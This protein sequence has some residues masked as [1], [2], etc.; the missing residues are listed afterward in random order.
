MKEKRILFVGTAFPPAKAGSAVVMRELLKRLDKNS[1]KVIAMASDGISEDMDFE[2]RTLRIGSRMGWARRFSLLLRMIN[3]I[4]LY[5]RSRKFAETFSPEVIVAPYPSLDF[6][7]LGGLLARS[8]HIP[9]VPYL[10]D[11]I[12]EASEKGRARKLAYAVQR[13]V[14]KNAARILVMSEGMVDL[15]KRKYGLN[16]VAIP[17]IYDEGDNFVNQ[18][19]DKTERGAFWAGGV[20]GINDKALKRV[21][22]GIVDAGLKFKVTSRESRAHLASL[23]ISGDN[24]EICTLP[25]R[26]EYLSCLQSQ[27]VLILALNRPDES[28]IGSDEL[29]TIFPTKTPEYLASGRPI[30]VH[31][32][33]DYFLA[34]FFKKHK[35]GLVVSDKTKEFLAQSLVSLLLDTE[36]IRDMGRKAKELATMFSSKIVV[37]KF[38]EVITDVAT[39]R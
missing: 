24:V 21:Y 1:Y 20:Y 16:A 36:E 30:L 10:H 25:T 11:T 15:Y 33:E 38:L 2:S 22:D 39:S 14:F 9:F 32:P 29:A 19:I 8:L 7:L 6:L 4:F 35:C 26:S 27:G 34:R 28:R 12:F 37:E 31:C 13:F 3:I 5:R 18:N 23:G 17:H